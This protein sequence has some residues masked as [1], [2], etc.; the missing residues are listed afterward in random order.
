[1]KHFK[2]LTIYFIAFL[3]SSFGQPERNRFLIEITFKDYLDQ[4]FIRYSLSDDQIKV[5]SSSYDNFEKKAIIY[6]RGLSKRA[7]DS[8]YT[9]LSKLNIDTS[10]ANCNNPVLDGLWIDFNIKGEGIVSTY[11]TTHS[12]ITRTSSDLI[13]LVEKQIL[14][15]RFTYT[16]VKEGTGK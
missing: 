7:S 6:K 12:C 4:P 13:K 9:Y 16:R 8:V 11:I 15:K 3:L 14:K 5:E 1:M 10:K 2:L